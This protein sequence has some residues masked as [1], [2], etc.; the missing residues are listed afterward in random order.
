MSTV[1]VPY[2]FRTGA[3]LD[4]EDVN[5]NLRGIA[6]DIKRNL[7]RRYTYWDVSIPLDGMTNALSSVLRSIEFKPPADSAVVIVGADLSIYSASGVTWTLTG[8]TDWDGCSV[9]TAGA[10]TEARDNCAQP[11][12]VEDTAAATF[13]LAASGASTITRGTLTLS[14]RSDRGSQPASA[15][16]FAPYVP[17]PVDASTTGL[18]AALDAQLVAAQNAVLR[19][20]AAAKDYRC[21]CILVR[22]LAAAAV[23]SWT[24]PSG[25]GRTAVITRGYICATAA[26]AVTVAVTGTS[27]LL[28]GT[29]TSNLVSD[30]GTHSSRSDDPT[31]TADDTTATITA[32]GAGPVELAYAFIWW[33]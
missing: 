16:D 7:D 2:T 3:I 28:T 6:R 21:E 26:D 22:D 23:A 9:D 33:S 29:G 32:G 11:I 25:A 4:G 10:T 20:A 1:L 27:L 19:D 24:L 14:M 18:A 31:D 5:A 13:L 17:T 15:P 8:P 12:R 30:S